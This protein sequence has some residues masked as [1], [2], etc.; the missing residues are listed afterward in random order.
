VTRPEAFRLPGGESTVP[1]EPEADLAG[2]LH[3]VSN[4]L[5]VV[6]GWLEVAEARGAAGEDF[7]EAVEVARTHALLGHHIARRAIGADVAPA[8]SSE[9]PA[10]RLARGALTAVKPTADGR[11]I[12]VDF[13][14]AGVDRIAIRDPAAALQIL[15][16]LLLNAIELSPNGSTVSLSVQ[17]DDESVLFRVRDSGPGIA[18]DRA[19]NLFTA[20]GS[21]RAGGA[22]IG[23]RHSSALARSKGGRLT[24]AEGQPHA[25]FALTWPAAGYFYESRRPEALTRLAAVRIL[26]VEDDAAV[27]TLLELSLGARGAEVVVAPTAKEFEQLVHSQSFDAALVDLSPIADDVGGALR[28]LRSGSPNISIIL[29]SG[30]TSGFPD[31]VGDQ[32]A[33][34]VRKPFEMAELVEVLES[35]LA[36]VKSEL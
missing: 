21:T 9:Q 12:R 22:G 13:E 11:N 31:E 23:L 19:L 6:L 3:E 18:P 2:A 15:T 14:H 30:V 27:R 26:L 25:I 28:L 35:S 5:T 33:A 7:R 20:A 17:L 36:R 29:I 1:A 32:V 16:N 10:L 4:T 34:W 8:S 24:L